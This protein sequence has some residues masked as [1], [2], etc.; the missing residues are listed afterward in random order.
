[1]SFTLFASCADEVDT[2]NYFLSSGYLTVDKTSITLDLR[3]T[4]RVNE[5]QLATAGEQKTF[6]VQ[7]NATWSIMGSEH[8]RPGIYIVRDAG[9]S[10]Q[11]VQLK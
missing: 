7:S 8:L 1:M 10:Q 4:C 11:K 6:V 2:E 3:Y 5:L 9:G